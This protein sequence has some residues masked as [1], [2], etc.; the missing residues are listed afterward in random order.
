MVISKKEVF[1]MKGKPLVLYRGLK[2]DYNNL[3]D[4]QFTGQESKVNYD[5]I[6]DQH[7]R[8]TVIDGN[9]YGVYMSDNLQMVL[10]AYGSLHHDGIP[11]DNSLQINYQ[12]I[13][14][15]SVAVIYEINPKGLNIRKPFITDTLKGHYNNGILG[16]EWIA[17][18]IPPNNYR[19]YQVKIGKDILHDEEEINLAQ[20][21]DIET[22]VK[23]KIAMRKYRL[24]V[25]VN[26][27]KKIPYATRSFWTI[28]ELNVLKMIYGANGLKYINEECII[29][30]TVLGMLK[31]LIAKVFKQN[32]LE[33]DFQTIE[34]ISNLDKRATDIS[35]LI[36]II[37]SDLEFNRQ[38][39]LAFIERKR[40]AGENFTT[41]KY[42]K[43]ERILLHLLEM[44]IARQ[45]QD[46]LN[47]SSIEEYNPN[48][49][50][51]N[52]QRKQ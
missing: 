38:E 48:I 9:E 32:E 50:Q 7:G 14:I 11:V 2:I 8:K 16:D 31:Y 51:G 28:K 1:K 34:Y 29:T 27:M 49:S 21:K 3:L 18:S 47:Y 35:S 44:V 10:A 40:K 41:S 22:E 52:N 36:I 12:R 20:V 15:P 46:D 19:L 42:D 23:D 4:Y 45:K 17:D 33:I 26:A 13:L 39:R 37:K 24:E 25:F 6:I 43:Q 5:P 30:S